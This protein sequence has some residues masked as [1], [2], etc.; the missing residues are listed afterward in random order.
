M[1]QSAPNYSPSFN[2]ASLQGFQTSNQP[3][4][5]YGGN[6]PNVQSY[7]ANS[8]AS[9]LPQ[10][11]S[12]TPI[13]NLFGVQPAYAASGSAT[14]PTQDGQKASYV[15]ASYAP[16][17]QTQQSNGGNQQQQ[18]Q[19]GNS[20]GNPHINP[21]TG[22]WDDN[23]FAQHNNSNGGSS[24]Y[25]NIKNEIGSG[26]DS[27]IQGLQGQQ[28]NLGNEYNDM[29]GQVNNTYQGQQNSLQNE[30][31]TDLNNIDASQTSAQLNQAKNLRDLSANYSTQLQNGYNALGTTGAGDSSANGMFSYATQHAA[32]QARAN[33]MGQYSGVQNQINL[34]R[35]NL[36]V[37]Y[38]NQQ[39][40]L[41]NWKNTQMTGLSQWMNDQKSKFSNAIGMSG[42]QKA[43]AMAAVDQSALQRLQQLDDQATQTRQQLLQTAAQ[44]Q[45][46]LGQQEVTMAAYG[47]PVPSNFQPTPF[48]IN[49]LPQFSGNAGNP[50]AYQVGG[51]SAGLYSGKDQNGNPMAGLYDPNNQQQG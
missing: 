42:Q 49:T 27:Y 7:A 5:N 19:Q 34:N 12:G 32:G 24:N 31:K 29:S 39:N 33:L 36:G 51:G 43:Q 46:Q 47:H 11:Y 38:Q 48:N 15:N 4:L 3:Q 40:Q 17:P 45:V 23:Y 37:T 21:A 13:R 28:A 6:V 14:D 35:N 10:T 41:D 1:S 44:G 25:G 8:I 22:Q 50:S 16:A 30:N 26:F 18:Q 9:M 20:N 2:P